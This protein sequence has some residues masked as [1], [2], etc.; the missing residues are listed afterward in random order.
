MKFEK[1]PI[2]PGIKQAISKLGWKKPTDIQFKTIG[3]V[4]K[5]DDILAIAQTGTG[6]TAAFVIPVLEWEHFPAAVRRKLVLEIA[7]L[8]VTFLDTAGLRDTEDRLE[9]AGIDRA[10]SRA[11]AADLRGAWRERMLISRFMTA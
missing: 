7:G 9:Q 1:Y 11:E 10:L 2:H 6:K 5:G 8:P 4:L 3:P